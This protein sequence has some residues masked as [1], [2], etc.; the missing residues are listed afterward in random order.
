MDCLQSFPFLAA[1]VALFLGMASSVTE[2]N[3][4]WAIMRRERLLKINF[5]IWLASKFVT[6][7]AANF[8][9]IAIYTIVALLLLGVPEL[10]LQYILFLWLVSSV[11]RVIGFN[12]VEFLICGTKGS[13]QRFF[14]WYWYRS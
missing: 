10:Y 1:I 3:K 5:T 8:I 11:G 12:V 13:A 14:R 2:I 7:V 6:L 9:P 4:E